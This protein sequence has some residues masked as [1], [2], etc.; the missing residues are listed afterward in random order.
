M[1][2]PARRGAGLDSERNW[3]QIGLPY[4][5]E[6]TPRPRRKNLYLKTSTQHVM[7]AIIRSKIILNVSWFVMSES[8]RAK[9]AGAEVLVEQRTQKGTPPRGKPRAA[10]RRARHLLQLESGHFPSRVALGVHVRQG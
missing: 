6:L 10:K 3:Q 2:C 5:L 9:A 1:I 8:R 7:V 4:C